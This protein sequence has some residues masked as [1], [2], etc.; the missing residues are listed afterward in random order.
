VEG[1]ETEE[2]LNMVTEAGCDT[3][4]GYYFYKPLEIS[5]VYKLFASIE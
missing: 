2:E 4:Q 5:D 3:V 1:V